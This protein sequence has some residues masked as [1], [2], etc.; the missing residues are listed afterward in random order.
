MNRDGYEGGNGD[1]IRD[2]VVAF[3]PMIEMRACAGVELKSR[4]DVT[5]GM[6]SEKS[7]G[8][9]AE[10]LAGN[11]RAQLRSNSITEKYRNLGVNALG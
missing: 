4:L 11:A 3:V 10:T 9:T 6:R 5:V 8:A 2:G 1:E 7:S